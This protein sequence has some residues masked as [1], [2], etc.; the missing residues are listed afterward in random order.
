[1]KTTEK[2][3]LVSFAVGAAIAGFLIYKGAPWHWGWSVGFGA[4]IATGLYNGIIKQTAAER[5]VDRDVLPKS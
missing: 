1:M 4:F 2:I 5:I 3:G